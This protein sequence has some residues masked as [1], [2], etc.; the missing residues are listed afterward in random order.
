MNPPFDSANLFSIQED[1]RFPVNA[2]EIQ[3]SH[4]SCSQHR[5]GKLGPIPEVGI[6]ERVRY[7]QMVLAKI[8]IRDCPHIKVRGE[9]GARHGCHYPCGIVKTWLRDIPPIA[10]YK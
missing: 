8:R 4:L 3:P 6:E 1:I 2:V 7:L 5:R 9:H 10:I